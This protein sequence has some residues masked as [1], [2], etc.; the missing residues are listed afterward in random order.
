MKNA[1]D[2]LIGLDIGTSR[3][4]AARRNGEDYR[5]ESQLNAFVRIP[6]S[7]MTLNVLKKEQVPHV[8]N[9]QEIT[10]FGNEASR[11]ADLLN[12]DTRRPM[13]RGILNPNEADSLSQI[14]HVIGAVLGD[15][16][17]NQKV[18]FSVPAPPLG[19]E[20]NLTY[21]EATLKGVLEEMGYETRSI[22]EGLAVIYSELEDTNYTGVG[23]SCGGGLCNVSVAY[24]S[25]PVTSFST[26]KGGDFIDSSASAVT[27][28][29]SNRIRIAKEETFHFNGHFA[30]KVLQALSVYY[31][32]LI[33][34]VMH[35]LKEA[36]QNSRNV[37]R[38]GKPIPLVLSG[39]S[40]MPPGFRDRFEKH[41]ND[42]SLPVKFSEV[43]L[44]KD[45]LNATAKGALVAVMAD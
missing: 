2:N 39:G 9:E 40:A 29:L 35:G 20:A 3:I 38:I 34:S 31:D 6:F 24:M 30:D 12:S 25:V 27:G 21:H 8:V 5:Y 11:F 13:T 45:P 23:V 16:K 43:R 26:P 36:F 44:A 1:N 19:Y 32:D 10:V 15:E 42:V 37:P 41:L 17:K 22:N 4:V 7:K 18:C 14:R 28:E 33:Q